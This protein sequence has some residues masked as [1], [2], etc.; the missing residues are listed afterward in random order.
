MSTEKCEQ[1]GRDDD[2]GGPHKVG[3]GGTGGP[4]QVLPM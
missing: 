4:K 2:S 3:A 1:C